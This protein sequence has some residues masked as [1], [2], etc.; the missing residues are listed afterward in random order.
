M[1]GARESE[2]RPPPP[3]EP[4]TYCFYCRVADHWTHD[5]LNK[6]ASYAS[7]SPPESRAPAPHLT[8]SSDSLPRV[9]PSGGAHTQWTN[10]HPHGPFDCEHCGNNTHPS[11]ECPTL[12]SL[13]DL[14]HT[15]PPQ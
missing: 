6:P 9:T 4:N 12:A 14:Y 11:G 7:P 10:K 1:I 15:A 8:P 2:S 3:P 5:C 13:R